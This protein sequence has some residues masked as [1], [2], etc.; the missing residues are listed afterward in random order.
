MTGTNFPS[1]LKSMGVPVLGGALF[2]TG[3]VFF[4]DS[5]HALAADNPSHGSAARPFASISY[6]VGRC[7]ANN[8]DYVIALPG[9]SEAVIAAGGINFSV[10]G[11]NVI[12]LGAGDA[13][14]TIDF[15]T[16]GDASVT[17]TSANC[18]MSNILFTGGVDALVSPLNVTAPDFRLMHPEYR[19]VTGQATRFLAA[20]GL[21]DRMWVEGLVYRGAAAAGA[22]QA[23]RLIGGDDITVIPY[24]IDGNFSSYCID[25]QTTAAVN[26]R[27]IGS[28]AYP[29][30]L[31]NRNSQDGIFSAVATTTGC[32]GPFINARIADDAA[33]ITEA[34]VGA[35]MEF[36]QPINIVNADGESSIQ[37]NI[38]ASADA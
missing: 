2:T 23:V 10:E 34:F 27:I 28:A 12:G 25:N 3:Q 13:R 14:P 24:F 21:A 6:A 8:G 32:V 37:T 7:A 38:A 33:N 31:R 4:V 26:L 19:D 29:A 18:G 36:F 5:G 17:V 22:A 20:N 30:Y 35:D 15:T 11:V 9:H 1:G 16:D